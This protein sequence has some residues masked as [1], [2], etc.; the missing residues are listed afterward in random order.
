M[1]LIEITKDVNGNLKC[2]LSLK[3]MP[4]GELYQLI[5]VLQAQVNI[6]VDASREEII[7]MEAERRERD[8]GAVT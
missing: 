2:A 4:I 8:G 3:D 6:L 1:T 7:R 5:G